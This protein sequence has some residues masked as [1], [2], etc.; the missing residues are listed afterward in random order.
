MILASL[1][2]Y[3]QRLVENE[4]EG[5]PPYGFSQEKISFALILSDKGELIEARNIQDTSGKKDR[6]RSMLVPAPPKRAVNIEPCLFWDKTGYVLGVTASES[7][8][9]LARAQ[10]THEAFVQKHLAL[11]ANQDDEEL[12]A[13]KLF[14][15]NWKPEQFDDHEAFEGQDVLD[16]NVIF[17]LDGKRSYIHESKAAKSLLLSL[18]GSGEQAANDT[19]LVTGEEQSIARLHPAIKGVNGA[20]SSGASLVSFNLD[21]FTSYN[22]KQGN[23]APISD[24]VAFSYT[25]VLNYLLRRDDSN[26]QRLQMGDTSVV[27]WANAAEQKQADFAQN[28]FAQLLEP[29]FETDDEKAKATDDGKETEK[30]NNALKWV[31]QGKPLQELDANINPDTQIFILGLAPNASRLSIRFFETAS[32]QKFADRLAQHY[33]DLSLK[34]IP[35]KNE[36]TVWR[37][38]L[39]TVPHR[40]GSRPKLDDIQPQLAGEV[41]R[42]ILTG[43]RYPRSLLTNVIMRLRADG[44]V[45][46]L[47]VALIKG[48]LMREKRLGVKGQTEEVPMGLDETSKEP[49]YLLGR[50]FSELEYVQKEAIGNVNASIK[51]KY[52]G[53]ASATPANVFPVLIKNYHNHLSKL[54]KGDERS[55]RVAG[56]VES[57]VAGIVD[58][59]DISFPK[60]LR[61]E[62][63]GQFAIGYYHQRNKRFTKK[64]TSEEGDKE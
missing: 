43:N 58:S 41:A 23:N 64:H 16:T 11:L 59:L 22:K 12:V 54:R 33:Q 50:L 19:C 39:E 52:F 17:R 27:F 24:E 48:V 7:E 35:W 28:V 42:A 61:I 4:V 36:P 14:L 55:K 18:A 62:A 6:P 57:A 56:S 21:S 53:A 46:A 47:R 9:D 2:E 10:K 40:E 3:Y 31:A 38:L 20:Q 5:V 1:H 45:S 29:K 37:L 15:E 13:L 34:P 8:K 30:L 51:D 32:L 44:D 26:R 25:T 63:Q 49:G 60:T